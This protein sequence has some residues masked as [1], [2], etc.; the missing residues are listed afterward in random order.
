VGAVAQAVSRRLPAA[1]ARVRAQCSVGEGFLL[2]FQ[3][4]SSIIPPT[5]PYSSSSITRDWCNR[6]NSGRRPKR[7]QSHPNTRGNREINNMEVEVQ[8]HGVLTSAIDGGKTSS[9]AGPYRITS[10][11][12][13]RPDPV[14][15][16]QGA[17]VRLRPSGRG[18]QKA[19]S[20]TPRPFKTKSFVDDRYCEY[21]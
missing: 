14:S 7:T 1:E 10:C 3:F 16:Q 13:R 4:S 5:A 15:A 17:M 12:S 11:K 21:R 19:V 9:F 8:I 6:L 20:K 2:V 18:W